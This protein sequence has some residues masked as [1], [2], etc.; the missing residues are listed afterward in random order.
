MFRKTVSPCGARFN[1]EV[2]ELSYGGVATSR[3]DAA[4]SRVIPFI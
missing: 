3:A 2:A 4:R 1:I